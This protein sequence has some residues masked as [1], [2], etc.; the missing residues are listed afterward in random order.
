VTGTPGYIAPEV[1]RGLDLITPAI[2]VYALGVVVFEMLTGRNP[3]L[4]G[5][6]DLS[7]VLVRHGT[8]R[9]PV[10]R[11]APEY[12]DPELAR[13]LADATA[14]DPRRRPTVQQFLARWTRCV[15]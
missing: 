15:G 9:L 5:P 8:Q 13:L 14:A 7:A 2:D 10:E 12:P 11:M 6:G 4:E 3:Y 1:A